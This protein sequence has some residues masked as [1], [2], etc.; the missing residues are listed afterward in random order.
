MIHHHAPAD[1][2]IRQLIDHSHADLNAL[3]QDTVSAP[4]GASHLTQAL[5]SATADPQTLDRLTEAIDAMFEASDWLN[6]LPLA[7]RLFM[8]A[9][10]DPGA[11][12]RLGTCLQ[13]MGKPA[14]AVPVFTHCALS[15]GD[16]PT[17]GPLLRLGEC[18]AAMGQVEPALQAFDACMEVARTDPA[19]SALQE[20][21]SRKAE[22]LRAR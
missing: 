17:P 7:T 10:A 3:V 19:H 5:R 22:A 12:Y 16:Q 18:L 8:L 9:A 11:S 21:A 15:E 6:A 14:E 20:I 4:D 2:E 13:R 1:P